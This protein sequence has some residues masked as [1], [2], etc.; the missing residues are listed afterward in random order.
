MTSRLRKYK[1]GTATQAVAALGVSAMLLAACGTD[2]DTS[3]GDEV[4]GTDLGEEDPGATD[5]DG[6]EAAAVDAE[7]D[8]L[9]IGR[10]S[11]LEG[12]FAA[13]AEDGERTVQMVLEEY[14]H[15]VAGRPI[16]TI[17]ESSDTTPETAV[18]RARKLVEQDGVHII[19]GPLSGGEGAALA[20]Y[21]KSVPHVTFVDAASGGTATTLADPA[22]NYFRW[23]SEGAM[24]TSPLGAYTVEE[25]GYT[26]IATLAEDYAFPHSQVGGF[27]ES[28]CAAGGEVAQ[29]FWVPL[30][31]SD[32]SSVIA[33]I[34]GDIDAM[35]VSV[36]G[37]DAVDFLTQ[38]EEFGVDI[39]IIGGSILVTED[40]L[41]SEG[42]VRAASA[43]IVSSG[44]IPPASADIPEWQEFQQAY[45]DANPDAFDT[46]TLQA[47]L[48]Y[49]SFKSLLL[50]LEENDGVVEEDEGASLRETMSNL[51]WD[52][53]IGSLQ[54]NENRQAETSIFI[55][56]VVDEGGEQLGTQ[57]VSTA[58]GVQQGSENWARLDGC[59]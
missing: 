29:T 22:E 44:P 33:S 3:L 31:E 11:A 40:V 1:R 36:G 51:Q 24:W 54:L 15:Q 38:A 49:N 52:S 5:D 12:A 9:V 39:P 48:Y 35:F 7:G 18:D 16:R 42:D 56:E 58:E 17:V 30:G 55:Y 45:R 37:S 34:P 14:G 57:L 20:D 43:G 23:H 6:G 26:N 2:G 59:P 28:Y 10:I 53:P 27:L 41:S 8:E 47:V 13:S 32:Y 50:A 21:A 4:G 46:P 19:H 25:L